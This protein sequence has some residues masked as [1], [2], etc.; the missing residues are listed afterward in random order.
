MIKLIA[1]DMDGTL[2]DSGRLITT[3]ANQVLAHYGKGMPGGIWSMKQ[4]MQWF[5]QGR[6]EDTMV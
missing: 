1:F 2:T 3:F 5:L 6:G 4:K